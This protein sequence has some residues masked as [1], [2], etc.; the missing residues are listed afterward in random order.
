MK[1]LKLVSIADEKPPFDKEVFWLIP[2]A[3]AKTSRE[4][5][6]EKTIGYI[7]EETGL[8][9]QI[10]KNLDDAISLEIAELWYKEIDDFSEEEIKF[11]KETDWFKNNVY[12]SSCNSIK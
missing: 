2:I 3:K 1:N 4:N 5:I 7:D 10:N 9:Y 6:Y 12:V 11:I 8:L